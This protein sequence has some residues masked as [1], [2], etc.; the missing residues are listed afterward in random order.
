MDLYWINVLISLHS[1][2][3]ESCRHGTCTNVKYLFQEEWTNENERKR[4]T[5]SLEEKAKWYKSIQRVSYE[6]KDKK[7]IWPKHACT[8]SLDRGKIEIVKHHI[9]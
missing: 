1:S 6:Y 4:T 5:V 3:T 8:Y 2:S 7:E 9:K